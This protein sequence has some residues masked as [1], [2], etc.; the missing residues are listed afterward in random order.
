MKTTY[1]WVALLS[2]GLTTAC[3]TDLIPSRQ[4]SSD[5]IAQANRSPHVVPV[6]RALMELDG[7]LE[8]ID[9]GGTR[10]GGER[11]VATVET[12]SGAAF[13]QT[14]TRAGF[15]TRAEA[16]TPDFADA[17]EL[18]YVVNFKDDAGY[19]IL[20][21]DDRMASVYAI[22]DQGSLTREEFSRVASMSPLEAEM[23]EQNGEFVYPTRVVARAVAADFQA[24]DTG[25]DFHG[26]LSWQ[27]PDGGTTTRPVD[28]DP[29]VGFGVEESKGSFLS[30][31][32]PVKLGQDAPYNIECPIR[33]GTH[34][35]AG[36]G[37]IALAQMA[38]AN[39]EHHEYHRSGIDGI[40]LDW[41]LIKKSIHSS[42]EPIAPQ[43]EGK[44][45]KMYIPGVT[46]EK[47]E[48]VYPNYTIELAKM[49]HALGRK[50]GMDYGESESG[51]SMHGIQMALEYTG[52]EGR[53]RYPYQYKY[54]RMMLR[55][56]GLTTIVGST[57]HVHWFNLDGWLERTLHYTYIHES[58][59]IETRNDEQEL[60]HCNFGWYGKYNGYYRYADFY[61]AH[62]PVEF[63]SEDLNWHNG[64]YLLD[65]DYT[66]DMDNMI[67][68]TGFSNS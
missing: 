42:N 39:T 58:G 9:G 53:H 26:D 68:Y 38:L 4:T 14:T 10:A 16:D 17:A 62:G 30:P 50:A 47:K 25:G 61:F 37:A 23:A 46:G 67:T 12:L 66:Y 1:L 21:A 8:Q 35:V 6:D 13:V 11:A 31:Q 15:S 7:L 33:G 63:D 27:T 19:A 40:P 41:N 56:R 43:T 65:K 28:N 29:V 44:Q 52:Y 51:C 60:I 34:A 24:A 57:N 59:K 2:A 55:D 22:T 45:N 5:R 54:V 36:C 48:P 18:L 20:G 64:D 32:I 49:I 3:Q